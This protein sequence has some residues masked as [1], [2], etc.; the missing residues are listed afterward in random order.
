MSKVTDAIM[1]TIISKIM[2]KIM[3]TI[4]V[5]VGKDSCQGDSGGP[6]VYR[7]FSDDP[8]TQV[9]IVSFG[10]GRCGAGFPAVYTKVEAY[11]DWIASKLEP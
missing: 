7:A 4:Y 5:F 9:G 11:M 6:L 10:T 1:S 2:T 8:W 3:S